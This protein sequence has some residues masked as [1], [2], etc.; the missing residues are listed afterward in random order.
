MAEQTKRANPMS[1]PIID[2]VAVNVATGKA[3]EPLERA[4]KILEQI[5]GQQPTY[6]KAKT[7]VKDWGI[8]QGE[9][10]ACLVTLRQQRA[11]EFLKRALSAVGNK[12][13]RESFDERGNVAFGIKEHIELPGTRYD[14]EL[15]IVGMDICVSISKRGYRVKN[16]AHASSKVGKRHRVTREEAIE[17]MRNNFAIQIESVKSE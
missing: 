16:R 10:I 5:A 1:L 9:P 15:G 3:G 12:L 11:H 14:P 17:L 2:K 8:R 4:A 13:R 6:R 7:T